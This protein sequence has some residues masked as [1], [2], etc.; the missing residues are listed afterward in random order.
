MTPPLLQSDPP[1]CDPSC[2][3]AIFCEDIYSMR[4]RH[5]AYVLLVLYG[6]RSRVGHTWGWKSSHGQYSRGFCCLRNFVLRCLPNSL[7]FWPLGRF[8]NLQDQIKALFSRL[9]GV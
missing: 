5:G 3:N 4:R 1:A 8:D 9:T 7:H 6:N 2:E